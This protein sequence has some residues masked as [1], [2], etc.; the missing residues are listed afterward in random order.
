MFVN[1]TFLESF[2]VLFCSVQFC[3]VLFWGF[4]A[5]FCFVIFCFIFIYFV[6]LYFALFCFV[7]E[8]FIGTLFDCWCRFVLF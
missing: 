6:L 1:V 4:S 8:A 7:L 3:L 2:L 5:V